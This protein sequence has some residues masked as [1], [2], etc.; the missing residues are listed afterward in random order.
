MKKLIISMMIAAV[1]LSSKASFAQ[2]AMQN[3]KTVEE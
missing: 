3:E 1:V 2:A